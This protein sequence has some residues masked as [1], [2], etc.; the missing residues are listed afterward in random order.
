MSFTKQAR[1]ISKRSDIQSLITTMWP[2]KRPVK[3]L[4]K[5]MAEI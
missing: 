4:F 5:D 2:L 1:A 3:N